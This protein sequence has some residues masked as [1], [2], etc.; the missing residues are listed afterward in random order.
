[1]KTYIILL[2]VACQSIVALAQDKTPYLTKSL[3]ADAIKKVFVSTSGGSITVSG[4]KSQQPRVEVYITGNNNSTPSNEEIKKRLAEDYSLEVTVSG[5]ELHAVAKNKHNGDW[6]WRKSLNIAF[7]VYVSGDVA[8]NLETSGGSIH[9]DNLHGEE[10]FSTSGGSLNIDNLSGNIRGRTSGGSINVSNT[11]EN[12]DLE[13]SGGSIRA[14]NCAGEIKLNTSGGSLNLEQLDGRINAT[15][16]GGSIRGSSIKGE[17]RTGTS[18]G[19]INL[20]DLACSLD[21]YTSGGSINVQLTQLGKFVKIDASSGHVELQLPNKGLNL[22]LRG[23]R[24]SADLGNN[25][26]GTKDK[27]RIDGKLN[28]GR[29]PVDVN[30]G[31]H[32]NLT[33]N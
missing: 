12:I 28:G 2:F 7:K 30:G 18:G 6:D 17:L 23:S 11:K 1:M 27:D 5:N 31:S 26:S 21:T 32:V 14:K 9:L 10:R 13:T 20:N 3:S 29:I 15:T 8:T 25:F 16:S 19:S 33:F 4:D 22:N 24:V